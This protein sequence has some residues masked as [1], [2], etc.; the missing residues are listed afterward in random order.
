MTRFMEKLH[1]FDAGITKA[2]VD[3]WHNGRV[4]IDGVSHQI[5][6]GLIVEVTGFS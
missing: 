3:S 1:G 6:E 4:K 2:M 5:T